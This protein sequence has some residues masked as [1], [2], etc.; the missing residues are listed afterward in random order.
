MYVCIYFE[1]ERVRERT[2]ERQRER[3]REKNLKQAPH[4]QCGA[5]CGARTHKPGDL[6]VSQML[7]QLSHPGAPP[8]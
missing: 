4:C 2:W 7:N 5:Q 8:I 6:D 1:R 3:E